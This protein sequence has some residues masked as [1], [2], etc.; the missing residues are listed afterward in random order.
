MP[1]FKIQH[2]TTYNYQG[3]VRDSA[4]KIMLYPI[5]DDH[6]ELISHDITV[7]GDPFIDIYTD[8]YGNTVGSFTHP[9]PHWEMRINSQL[10]V[11]TKAVPLPQD[12]MFAGSQWDDLDRLKYQVPYIDYLKQ[13]H[14]EGLPELRTIVLNE[15]ISNH[16]PFQ[17]AVHYCRYVYENFTYIKGITSVEST[18]DDIWKL[19]AGV[20]QDFAHILLVMLRLVNVPARYVSGYICPNKNDMRGDGATHAWVEAYIP[21]YGWLGLDPTNDCVANESHIR[22]AV[23]RN[24]TDCSPI[25]GVYKGPLDHTLNVIVLVSYEDGTTSEENTMHYAEPIPVPVSEFAKNSYLRHM[26]LIKEQQQQQQQ[27]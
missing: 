17:A 13:E 6:Q 14:F 20:C 19:K 23:G 11:A 18:L 3:P 10:I 22:L 16:T 15:R 25:K 8:Y 2:L 12:D 7:T 4:N 24:F 9:D 5:E 1:K 27:Q 21:N 26:A